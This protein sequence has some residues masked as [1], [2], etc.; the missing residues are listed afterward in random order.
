VTLVVIGD[1]AGPAALGNILIPFFI[2]RRDGPIETLVEP[3]LSEFEGALIRAD[4]LWFWGH[5][6]SGGLWLRK[7]EFFS[8]GD[9]SR[10]AAK[11][12]RSLGAATLRA[13]HS[14]DTA[15][16]V[17]AWLS[18]ARVVHG[19]AGVTVEPWGLT[20]PMLT[21]DRPI[22]YDPRDLSAISGW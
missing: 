4:R 6:N 8:I 9:V 2:P 3:S 19:F 10:I 18:L 16:A 5:G 22:D 1:R 12:Q 21:F 13:C 7:G 14:V 11:R 20:R 15:R 17:R